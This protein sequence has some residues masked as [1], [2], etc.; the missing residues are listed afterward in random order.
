[1]HPDKQC[2]FNCVFRNARM[3]RDY[4]HGWLLL[5]NSYC[6]NYFYTWRNSNTEWNLAN[7]VALIVQ[8]N[9]NTTVVTTT[10]LTSRMPSMNWICDVFVQLMQAGSQS[11]PYDLWI[12]L[13]LLGGTHRHPLGRVPFFLCLKIFFIFAFQKLKFRQSGKA[14]IVPTFK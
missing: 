1:M 7:F 4:L 2:H 8:L 14:C 6:Y 12:Y 10:I 5:W 11:A 9:C 13:Y 3:V